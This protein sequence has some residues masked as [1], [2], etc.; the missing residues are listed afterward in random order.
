MPNS[1]NIN[2]LIESKQ[3][4]LK[5]LL[6]F[7]FSVEWDSATVVYFKY[8]IRLLQELVFDLRV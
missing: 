2:L 8:S 1:R 7:T 6:H 5:V 3:V 4:L